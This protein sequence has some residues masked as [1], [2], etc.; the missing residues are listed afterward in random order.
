MR[1]CARG[2]FEQLI[3]RVI[4]NSGTANGTVYTVHDIFGNV[5]AELDGT[6]A[7]VREYI[8]LPEAVSERVI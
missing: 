7:T 2:G 3:S 4:T 1:A 8:W 6:G 5:I